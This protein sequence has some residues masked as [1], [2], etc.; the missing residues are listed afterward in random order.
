M[1]KKS[2]D[3]QNIQYTLTEAKASTDELYPKSIRPHENHSLLNK[4]IFKYLILLQALKRK[5]HGNTYEH[6]PIMFNN[7]I[8]RKEMDIT[9]FYRLLHFAIS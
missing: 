9:I 8:D 7:K 1:H 3:V 2:F 6:M 4:T 5:T